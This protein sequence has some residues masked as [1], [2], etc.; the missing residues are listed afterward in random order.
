MQDYQC[1]LRFLGLKK[2]EIA[3]VFASHPV[4]EK[5]LT[6]K[7]R[8]EAEGRILDLSKN[9]KIHILS[10]TNPHLTHSE[11]TL[12][13]T[14]KQ[15]FT[16][17]RSR[18]DDDNGE[19]ERKA[20][21]YDDKKETNER[22]KR[23]VAA[24]E[25]PDLTLDIVRVDFATREEE[26]FY[27]RLEH[28]VQ[29]EVYHH[30]DDEREEVE[31]EEVPEIS[32]QALFE[33]I[34]R[35]RQA[36]VNPALVISGYRRKF[37]G[38]IPANL[39][40]LDQTDNVVMTRAQRR[41]H[42]LDREEKMMDAI[43]IPSKTRILQGMLLNHHHTEKAIIFCEFREEMPHL[44]RDLESVGISCV[45][46]DGSLSLAARAEI[47]RRM[48]WTNQEV[49]RVVCSGKFFPGVRHVPAEVV[50]LIARHASYD[51]IIVQINSGN[52]GLNLQMCSRVYYT[53]P[54]WNPCTEIQAWGR[55]HRLGQTVPV[56]A[57]KLV[58][59]GHHLKNESDKTTVD[60]RVLDVQKEKRKIMADILGDED[61][62]FNGTEITPH[63]SSSAA[64]TLTTRDLLYMLG[65]QND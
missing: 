19:S 46:Y 15:V 63:V 49:A 60:Q 26:Q 47:V 43:G 52:A 30:E 20:S 12:R 50:N 39:L 37:R 53:N 7:V 21:E 1:L 22:K 16:R 23:R 34:L 8:K 35:L 11:L 45:L 5:Y 64:T 24:P 4:L 25:L 40:G 58:L 42:R 29:L 36:S 27:R 41:Q 59:S 3:H 18:D 33:L 56:A 55:A 62:L 31:H 51:A 2:W 9:G 54:N 6:E 38:Q 14:K 17:K 10:K 44:Q 61:I 57:V 48:S 65:A 28:A 32:D 13:R